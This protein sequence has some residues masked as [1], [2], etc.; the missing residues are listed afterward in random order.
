MIC[1]A[2]V[3]SRYERGRDHTRVARCLRVIVLMQ[4]FDENT[5]AFKTL[6]L[7][8]EQRVIDSVSGAI[9]RRR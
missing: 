7:M 3:R 5:G 9:R 1:G 6:Y 2:F 8:K 4:W